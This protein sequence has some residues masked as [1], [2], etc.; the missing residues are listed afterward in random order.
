MLLAVLIDTVYKEMYSILHLLRA[1]KTKSFLTSSSFTTNTRKN[2][3]NSFEKRIKGYIQERMPAFVASRFRDLLDKETLAQ[4]KE[5]NTD[6]IDSRE[7]KTWMAE[8]SVESFYVAQPFGSQCYPDFIVVYRSGGNI[9][10]LYIE[11]KSSQSDKARWNCSMAIPQKYC[12]YLHH[13][14]RKDVVYAA[15]GSQL[16]DRES[17]QNYLAKKREMSTLNKDTA[18]SSEWK[19]GYRI[20]VISGPS[21]TE[22]MVDDALEY[23]S[24]IAEDN[25]SKGALV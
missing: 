17:Y 21:F 24:T 11:C 25:T 14:T 22:A 19:V 15:L 7:L 1:I 23:L 3:S 8:Q 18:I 5:A 4:L 13:N 10:V 6:T 16:S 2:G 20:D 12:L 9:K